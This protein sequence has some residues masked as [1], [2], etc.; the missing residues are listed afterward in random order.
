[1]SKVA[2]ELSEKQAEHLLNQLS[3]KVKMYLVRRWEE[4]TWPERFRQLLARVDRRV[5]R[6]PRLA[7]EALQA[8]GPARRAFHA[9]H[10]RH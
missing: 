7:Q 8:I 1:M 2:V 4:E 9:S 5:R 3:P 10:G 6:R